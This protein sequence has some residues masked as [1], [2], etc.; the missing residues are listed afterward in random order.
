MYILGEKEGKVVWAQAG[1]DLGLVVTQLQDSFQSG[2]SSFKHSITVKYL[3]RKQGSLVFI[4][5]PCSQLLGCCQGS[6][7]SCSLGSPSRGGYSHHCSLSSSCGLEKAG[8]SPTASSVT[9]VNS[10]LERDLLSN[11]LWLSMGASP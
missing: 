8:I 5:A 6:G 3:A 2:P 11:P 4:S 1:L 7:R 9:Q 10:L